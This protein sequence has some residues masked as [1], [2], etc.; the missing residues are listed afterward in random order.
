M[1]LQSKLKNGDKIFIFE[2]FQ[3]SLQ[4]L[5]F[6][7]VDGIDLICTPHEDKLYSPSSHDKPLR[8]AVPSLNVPSTGA[9]NISIR[10]SAKLENQDEMFCS[11]ILA[12]QLRKPLCIGISGS[13]THTKKDRCSKPTL[14]SKFSI[15]NSRM[16]LN[17]SPKKEQYDYEDFKIAAQI[18]K[19]LELL[20]KTFPRIVIA[21]NSYL[22][23]TIG[24]STSYPMLFL[25][26]FLCLESLFAS[27]G[28]GKELGQIVGSFLKKIN[29]EYKWVEKW[30]IDQYIKRNDLAHGYPQ[31]LM[32]EN[33]FQDSVSSEQYWELVKL[34]EITRFCLL[35]ILGLEIE[36]LQ[37]YKIITKAKLYKKLLELTPSKVFV[38]NQKMFLKESM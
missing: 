38:E 10:I 22:H 28:K 2:K 36:Q 14:Y 3:C 18:F 21:L 34:Y 12:F 17:R 33:Q 32:I 15:I 19:K 31:F 5:P 24:G 4:T 11:I 23:V 9:R 35:G 16:P 27:P 7:I 26:L 30:I 25:E 20:K 8:Y 29:P 1:F 6:T 37:S 13:F